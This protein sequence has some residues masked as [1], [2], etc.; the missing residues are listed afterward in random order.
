MAE[1]PEPPKKGWAV[2]ARRYGHDPDV[3]K[4][5]GCMRTRGET[6]PRGKRPVRAR[7]RGYVWL[8]D[9]DDLRIRKAADKCNMT[10]SEFVRHAILKRLQEVLEDN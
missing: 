8:S 6:P 3:C 10:N 4:C 1:E 7:K 2:H 5:V 9:A